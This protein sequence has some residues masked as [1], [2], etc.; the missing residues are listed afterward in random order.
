MGI[1]LQNKG[2]TIDFDCQFKVHLKNSRI[3]TILACFAVLLPQLLI[4]FFQ[5]VLVGFGEYAMA[6][7]KKPF[8][9]KCGNEAAFIWK[10]RHGMKTKIH[11][12]YRW[13]ELQQLQVQCKLCGSK[14]YITRR[15][16]GM[17]PMKRIAPEIYRKLG[18]SGSLT[19][20]PKFQ[21]RP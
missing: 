11:G 2:I 3:S 17:E 21:R 20:V 16:L 5:K 10:T 18:L 12:F 15:L 14:M 7:K 9:C 8:A 13:L 1:T 6:L 4:D 19:F